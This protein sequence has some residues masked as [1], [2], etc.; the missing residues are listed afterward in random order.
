MFEDDDEI[1]P[2]KPEAVP[3]RLAKKW[4]ARES[5]EKLIVCRQCGKQILASSSVC[6]Y[7][8]GSVQSRSRPVWVIVAAALLILFSLLFFLRRWV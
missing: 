6:A 2:P 8:G 1:L 3:E 4:E 5:Q 7:C